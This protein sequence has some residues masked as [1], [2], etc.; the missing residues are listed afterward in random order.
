LTN[1]LIPYQQVATSQLA[2]VDEALRRIAPCGTNGLY[3]ELIRNALERA[4]YDQNRD[5]QNVKPDLWDDELRKLNN[6]LRRLRDKPPTVERLQTR[7]SELHEVTRHFL[8]ARLKLRS[9]T[10]K[11]LDDLDLGLQQDLDDLTQA[12]SNTRAAHRD[13]PGGGH[14]RSL[15]DVANSVRRVYKLASGKKPTLTSDT[16]A[17]RLPRQMNSYEELL[18][19]SVKVIKPHLTL[20]GARELDRAATGQRLKVPK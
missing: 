4:L 19:A 10:K 20:N 13:K 6:F 1:S 16:S 17:Q 18:L 5:K 12:I 8:N 14:H 11:G 7:I 15:H 2:P 3:S 9:D